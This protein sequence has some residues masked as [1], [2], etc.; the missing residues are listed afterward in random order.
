M[1]QTGKAE[2]LDCETSWKKTDCALT[3]AGTFCPEWQSRKPD[4]DRT[5][6]VAEWL[7]GDD[8]EA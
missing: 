2:K 7:H 3:E 1:M 4:A 6:H 5:D 8:D